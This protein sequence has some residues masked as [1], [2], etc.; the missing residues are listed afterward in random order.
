MISL[1]HEADDKKECPGRQAVVDHIDHP[2]AQS[3]HFQTEKPQ[4]TKAEVGHR[5][6]SH[7]LLDIGL[8]PG[9]QRRV[10]DSDD[11]Q[12]CDQRCQLER[13]VGQDRNAH[14]TKTIRAE[15]EQH[16]GKDYT[17]R[18]RSL[19][20]RQGQPGVKRK[21]RHLNRKAGRQGDE[22]PPLR[23]HRYDPVAAQRG[24]RLHVQRKP[25]GRAIGEVGEKHHAGKR[26]HATRHRIKEKL[27]GRPSPFFPSP[28]TDQEK[29]GNQGELEEHIEQQQ[30]HRAEHAEQA[31]LQKQ[32]QNVILAN[33]LA[34]GGHT[35]PDRQR[36]QQRRQ[37]DEPDTNSVHAYAI[38]DI[39]SREAAV[40]FRDP[41]RMGLEHKLARLGS[42]GRSL[43]VRP[44]SEKREQQRSHRYSQRKS[45]NNFILPAT[46]NK[47]Q[48]RAGQ[49]RK[50][51]Q[52]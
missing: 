39:H 52:C 5:R 46:G 2:A 44:H 27:V 16:T 23:I 8:D 34:D 9:C 38:T 47:Q 42:L 18:G 15:L 10:D 30:V 41:G 40:D 31:H 29:Q 33:P 21:Q 48:P 35:R 7:E 20:V 6:I 24:Q 11:G 45:R 50:N 37:H 28:D 1:V 51:N 43:V 22:Y 14:A 3:S 36:R 13:S 17:T 32:Q 12:R 26:Q 19:G 49:R 4:H 25:T